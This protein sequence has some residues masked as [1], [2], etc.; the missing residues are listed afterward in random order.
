MTVRSLYARS[1][2]QPNLLLPALQC[3]GLAGPEP[4]FLLLVG[5]LVC[6]DPAKGSGS[7][8]GP[9]G[10]QEHGKVTFSSAP[11]LTLNGSL[12]GSK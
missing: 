5:E 7:N 2:L 10:T 9:K 4:D 6:S 3:Y 8:W 11:D 12:N 1:V